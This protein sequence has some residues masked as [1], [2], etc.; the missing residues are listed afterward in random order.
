VATFYNG[1]DRVIRVET[2]RCEQ[3]VV[4]A[5]QTCQFVLTL[6]DPPADLSHYKLQSQAIRQ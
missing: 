4:E 5:G 3:E 6:E 1:E 2:T